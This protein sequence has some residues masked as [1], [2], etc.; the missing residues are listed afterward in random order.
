MIGQALP[1]RIF[2]FHMSFS[3]H[4]LKVGYI[5]DY[6]GEWYRGLVRGIL[7]V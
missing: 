3:L 2:M 4:S 7:G 5:G 1:V 6:I